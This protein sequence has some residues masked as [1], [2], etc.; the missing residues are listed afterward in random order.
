VERLSF[1]W[2]DQSLRV[3][4]DTANEVDCD[5][6]CPVMS[7]GAF[8]TRR[9]AVAGINGTYFCPQDYAACRGKINSFGTPVWNTF[10]KNWRHGDRIK[11]AA[12]PLVALDT[13]NRPFLYSETRN[14]TSA[15]DFSNN[16]HRT[17]KA[18][19]G[20]GVLQAAFSNGPILMQNGV[21]VLKSSQMDWKQANVKSARGGF[22]W[23]GNRMV[24]FVAHGATVTDLAAVAK[25]LGLTNAVNID[26]GGSTALHMNGRYVLGPGRNLPNV[27]LV[28]RR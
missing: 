7:L 6:N 8:V 27:I 18:A 14:F 28:T 17:S 5:T 26:G 3:V 22:G 19:G 15:A 13:T 11:Y 1:N 9:N 24:F 12:A 21:L 4:T 16:F 25:A 23:K 20:S 10:S 2:T